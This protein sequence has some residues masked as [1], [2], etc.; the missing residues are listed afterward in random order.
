MNKEIEY[1]PFDKISPMERAKAIFR[2]LI[3]VA[4][5]ICANLGWDFDGEFAWDTFCNVVTLVTFIWA[6]WKNNNITKNAIIAHTFKL[7]LDQA[8]EEDDA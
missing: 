7:T 4:A 1:E 2:L 6:W 5:F 3:P 8:K